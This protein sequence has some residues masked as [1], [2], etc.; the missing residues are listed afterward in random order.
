MNAND[1]TQ[2]CAKQIKGV[3]HGFDRRVRF[4]TYEAIG[5][6]GAMG[7]YLHQRNVSLMEYQKSYANE[8]R[9][10]MA[11]RVMT[12]AAEEGLTVT[13]VGAGQRKKAL[14]EQISNGA[15]G[16]K[17]SFV[18]LARW[19]GAV[20]SR[21]AKIQRL[22]SCNGS[23]VRANASISTSTSWMPSS[24]WATCASRRGRRSGCRPT[25][26]VTTGWSGS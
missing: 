19:S 17:G 14:V 16:A 12:V 4:G 8:L 5:W 26:T 21:S 10:E 6:A 7:R 24:A 13:Q 11:Q 2:R 15:A 18:S 22:D 25:S 3:L 9:L 23:L 1:L 20:V